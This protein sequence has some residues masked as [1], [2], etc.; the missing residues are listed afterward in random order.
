M[1]IAIGKKKKY[2]IGVIENGE[3]F[4]FICQQHESL[5]LHWEHLIVYIGFER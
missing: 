5:S 1:I 3:I 4:L 2:I